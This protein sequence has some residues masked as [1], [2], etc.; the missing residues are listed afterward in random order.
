MAQLN[1]IKWQQIAK[2]VH[3]NPHFLMSHLI[4]CLCDTS[5]D[6]VVKPTFCSTVKLT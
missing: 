5:W 4:R 1:T 6:V 2:N 3:V